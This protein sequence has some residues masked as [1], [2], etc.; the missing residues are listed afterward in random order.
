[1]LLFSLTLLMI[2]I[3]MYILQHNYYLIRGMFLMW[4]IPGPPAYPIIGSAH[5]IINK[6]STG[7]KIICSLNTKELVIS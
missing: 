1:M 7:L 2:S 6:T 4:K 3:V 5:L